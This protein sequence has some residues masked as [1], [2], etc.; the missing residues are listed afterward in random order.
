MSKPL[1]STNKSNFAN[2]SI[3]N[4]INLHDD[5]DN[6]LCNTTTLMQQRISEWS[7][8]FNVYQNT[9]N[10]LLNVLRSDPFN[11]INFPNDKKIVMSTL[12]IQAALQVQKVEP[13][14]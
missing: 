5:N 10:G 6:N 3:P 14:E 7:A 1:I 12:T 13:G 4:S 9:V 11:L 8:D 2:N